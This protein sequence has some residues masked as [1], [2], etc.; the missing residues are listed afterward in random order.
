MSAT[1][2]GFVEAEGFVPVFDAAEQMAKSADVEI[3]GIVSVGGGLVAVSVS[4]ALG[5]VVEAV[6]VAEDTIRGGHGI[7]ATCVVF[8]RPGAV[9]TR[10]AGNLELI[11]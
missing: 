2:I 11:G 7:G 1:A 8:A 4:G 9:V 5:Q 3:G 6:E 10:I